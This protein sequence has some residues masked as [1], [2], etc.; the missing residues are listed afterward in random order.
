MPPE[1]VSSTGFK[2]KRVNR[3]VRLAS[4]MFFSPPPRPLQLLTALIASLHGEG[5][6]WR[7]AKNVPRV[8]HTG[9]DCD[10]P[11]MHLIGVVDIPCIHGV[12]LVGVGPHNDPV[13]LSC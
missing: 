12:E 11:W 4:A 1:S 13:L 5:E 8:V 10:L 7:G 2:P 6:S 9:K 3:K